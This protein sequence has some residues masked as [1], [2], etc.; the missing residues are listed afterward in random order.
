MQRGAPVGKRGGKIAAERSDGVARHLDLHGDAGAVAAAHFQ[1]VDRAQDV[2]RRQRHLGGI[3]LERE[4]AGGDQRHR[5]ACL[6]DQF[7]A[8]LPFIVA[9]ALDQRIEIGAALLRQV[10]QRRGL[11][12]EG[13]GQRGHAVAETGVEGDLR[14]GAKR[15]QLR[16]TLLQH[17]HRALQRLGGAEARRRGRHLLAKRVEP[18]GVGHVIVE[19]VRYESRDAAHVS[20]PRMIPVGD[21]Q[22]RP[23]TLEPL[24]RC[25]PSFL[26]K[27]RG[28]RAHLFLHAVTPQM[29]RELSLIA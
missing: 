24:K 17:R 3:A 26:K 1:P 9:Q 14:C 12:P 27:N 13:V 15:H 21:T 2:F 25:R 8:Q 7:L 22:T 23:E 29:R 10:G 18:A 6:G 28:R 4:L 16:K 11:R 20:V 5:L 19:G